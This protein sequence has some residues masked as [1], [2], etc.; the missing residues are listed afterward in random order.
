MRFLEVLVSLNP[1]RTHRSL[2][3]PWFLLLNDARAISLT[4]ISA[5]FPPENGVYGFWIMDYRIFPVL[6]VLFE[7]KSEK[8]GVVLLFLSVQAY[9]Y[10][11]HIQISYSKLDFLIFIFDLKDQIFTLKK[12]KKSVVFL[13]MWHFA[14]A[15]YSCFYVL[16]LE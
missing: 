4:A 7:S 13:V 16:R 9:I 10:L 3:D 8:I 5:F 12:K 14:L 1:F 15:S 11:H 2:R 6:V